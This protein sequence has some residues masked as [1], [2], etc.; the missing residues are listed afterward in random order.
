MK[1]TITRGFALLVKLTLL[2][3][4]LALVTPIVWTAW[5]INQPMELESFGG[6]TYVELL[7]WMKADYERAARENGGWTGKWGRSCYD[8]H[9]VLY[10]FVLMP[11][12]FFATILALDPQ[13]LHRN[14]FVGQKDIEMGSAPD[15]VSLVEFL[16]AFWRAHENSMW[17]LIHD[18]FQGPT[19]QCRLSRSSFN[20][21]AGG[22]TASP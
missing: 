21:W 18:N 8:A 4:V 15:N 2:L 1:R 5:R 17:Y 13:R 6:H 12:E 10:H 22:Q 3:L 19:A 20:A 7:E 11:S 9:A 16:P 14:L